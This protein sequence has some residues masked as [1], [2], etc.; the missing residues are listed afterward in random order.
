MA[1]S[2][3]VRAGLIWTLFAIP[4]GHACTCVYPTLQEAFHSAS[5][6]YLGHVRSA[7]LIEHKSE[8]EL[9]VDVVEVFKGKPSLSEELRT[10]AQTSSCGWGQIAVAAHGSASEH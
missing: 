10:G 7:T 3:M 8:Y 5:S 4:Q 1:D 2:Y 6:V 9:I